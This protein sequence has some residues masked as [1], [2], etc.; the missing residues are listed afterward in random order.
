MPTIESS[1][2]LTAMLIGLHYARSRFTIANFFNEILDSIVDLPGFQLRSMGPNE[3]VFRVG[4][5]KIT[6]NQNA[7]IVNSSVA[8]SKDL[9]EC[10]PKKSPD[11]DAKQVLI[12]NHF[13]DSNF[14]LQPEIELQKEGPKGFRKNFIEEG[15]EI[16]R[17]VDKI[18]QGGLPPLRFA[19]LVEY[20]AV[21]LNTVKW[22]ILDK[23]TEQAE[24][25]EGMN[26]E[27]ISINRYY[28][29]GNEEEDERCLIFKLVKPNDYGLPETTMAGASFD[30]QLIPERPKN[31]TEF[32]SSRELITSLAWGIGKMIQHSKFMHLSP[33]S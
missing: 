32:G 24:I 6:L 1:Q 23:F 2:C 16:V 21:P 15:V 17:L 25:P 11:D 33:R 5:I 9:I 10:L 30:F 19:G 7:F 12:P 20:Y 13:Y 4:S 18:I 31:I 3:I 8:L 14:D 28:F 26:T 27:K 22:D 29:P